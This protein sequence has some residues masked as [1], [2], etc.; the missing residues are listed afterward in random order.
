MQAGHQPNMLYAFDPTITAEK[1]PSY[2]PLPPVVASPHASSNLPYQSA[3]SSRV[4]TPPTSPEQDVVV[5]QSDVPSKR[6]RALKIPC[7][8]LEMPAI[9]EDM[10]ATL[11]VALLG[12]V[13]FLKSQVPFPVTQLGRV[14]GASSASRAARKRSD[15]I[16]AFDELTSHLHTTFTA[17]SIALARNPAHRSTDTVYIALVLGPSI[18]V[19]R[20]RVVL[21]LEGLEVKIWGERD[22]LEQARM[23]SD[24]LYEDDEDEDDCSS[25]DDSEGDASRCGDANAEEYADADNSDVKEDAEE[26]PRSP[27][28]SE[29]P[30][31]RS[32]SPSSEKPSHP[33]SAPPAT[34][35]RLPLRPLLSS[36]SSRP[37]L[38]PPPAR[39]RAEEQQVLRAA[40]RLLARTL[41][42]AH[43]EGGG[44]AA[45]LAPTQTHV[46]LRAPRRFSHPAWLPR[47]NVSTSLDKML[48]DFVVNSGIQADAASTGGEGNNLKARR[49]RGATG[50]IRTE[51][52]LI[53]CHQTSPDDTGSPS[54]AYPAASLAT[55]V[56]EA[57][58][59][60]EL[61][62]WAWDGKLIG[63]ADW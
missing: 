4:S 29:P 13:L 30:S 2:H 51:G 25:D 27:P 1:M 35:I 34:S 53:T 26:P 28:A 43:A 19:P 17:L 49:R 38:A 40:E 54:H 52:V 15:M 6:D 45:E 62:W 59:E 44:M 57:R 14:P 3:A 32:P 18:G 58:E 16:T 48:Q 60:D 21:A 23:S 8:T 61:I 42:N 7:V 33:S 47:Q 10:A 11:A 5:Q 24:G 20:A 55:A 36:G 46:L 9:R 37:Y 12:H 39:T 41:V 56:T 63:F 31:S 22:D 50:G